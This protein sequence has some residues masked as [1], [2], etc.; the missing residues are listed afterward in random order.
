MRVRIGS[1]I[2]PF[3]IGLGF[4]A[5]G[6]FAPPDALTDDGFPLNTFLYFMGACFLI[7]GLL[8]FLGVSAVRNRQG[9]KAAEL[10]ET[11]Q[12]G[13]AQVLR[14]EDT[15]MRV[16]DNPRVT[17]LLEVQIPGHAPYQVEKTMV[18][19]LINLPQVQPGQQVAVLADP[20]EPQNPD[21][22]GLL[23]R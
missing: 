22:V 14:L 9:A 13:N 3:I 2:I 16:N 19:P 7:P 17:M 15:G 6:Y 10:M 1:S 18:V 23:L 21:K 4:L 8:S 11:G 12:Q 5:A 20:S